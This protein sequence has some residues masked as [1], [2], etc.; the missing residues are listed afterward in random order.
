MDYRFLKYFLGLLIH[1]FCISAFAQTELSSKVADFSTYLPIVSANIYIQ[2]TTLGTIS[3]SDGKFVLVVPIEFES[4]TLVV[5]SIGYKSFKIPINE[6]DNSEDIYLDTD[7]ASLD[8]V[9][10]IA[11][12]RPKTGN[13]IVLK[14]IEELSYNLPEEPYLQKG[15]LRHRER[16]RK[17]YKWLIESAIT[18]YDSSF[19]SGAE[20]NLKIN[21]DENRKSYDLREVDSLYAYAVYLKYQKKN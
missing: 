6:F 21:V 12:S 18:L 1:V 10:I 15:F 20:D 5:S 2:N 4:D 3:N 11:E 14:A 9:L 17:E 13:N 7:I 8:E 19:A 16:N